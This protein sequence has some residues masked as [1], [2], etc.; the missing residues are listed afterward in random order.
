MTLIEQLKTHFPQLEL[1]ANEPLAPFTTVKIGG[2]AEVFCVISDQEIFTQVVA[3]A[4]KNDIPVTILGWGANSLISDSGIK[5]L[6]IKNNVQEIVVHDEM[7]TSNVSDVKETKPRWKVI[8]SDDSPSYEF[9]D[10]DYQE[11]TAER[12]SVTLFAGVSLPSVINTLLNKGITGL[13]WYSRIP[14]S[15]GGAIYSN[16]HGGTHFIGELIT[17]VR[18]ITPQGEVKDLSLNT[19]TRAFTIQ[20]K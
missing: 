13:Q 6:V 8:H 19:T 17:S 14:A 3:F 9:N 5:G 1:K 18:V 2:P 4:K 20:T 12:V 16:I 10:L 11:E 7:P 15:V